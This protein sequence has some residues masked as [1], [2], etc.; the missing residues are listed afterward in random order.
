MPYS[1]QQPYNNRPFIK[2]C[3][4]FCADP[5]TAMYTFRNEKKFIYARCFSPEKI[6]VVRT[7]DESG[8]FVSS[9]DDRSSSYDKDQS[10]DVSKSR[11]WLRWIPRDVMCRTAGETH[12]GDFLPQLPHIFAV[13]SAYAG[14]LLKKYE[15]LAS[16]MR[17]MICHVTSHSPSVFTTDGRVTAAVVWKSH[18]ML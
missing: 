6:H 17:W 7:A 14:C 18:T 8:R 16:W 10:A 9:V 5:Q 4:A 15:Q 11:C 13:F 3:N 2:D 1:I 12:L